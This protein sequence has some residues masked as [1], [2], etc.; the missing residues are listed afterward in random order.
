MTLFVGISLTLVV[1]STSLDVAVAHQDRRDGIAESTRRYAGD[2]DDLIRFVEDARGLCFREQ[3]VI[4]IVPDDEWAAATRLTS[5]GA[6]KALGFFDWSHERVFVREH[7]DP[8]VVRSTI[9]HELVHALQWQQRPGIYWTPATSDKD[10]EA[11]RRLIEGDAYRIEHEYFRRSSG[12]TRLPPGEEP[13]YIEVPSSLRPAFRFA[14]TI[15][16]LGGQ[17]AIDAAF[18]GRSL[19]AEVFE[20]PEGFVRELRG[21]RSNNANAVRCHAR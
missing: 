14:E 11:R 5:P 20:D 2:F 1:L 13:W 16:R 21:Q 8:H 10:V 15:H 12:D 9:I 3:P 7:Q 6:S 18:D 17:A 19:S 4:V